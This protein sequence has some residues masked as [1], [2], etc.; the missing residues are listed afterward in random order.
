MRTAEQPG[1]GGVDAYDAC[2][3]RL[4]AAGEFS[5]FAN[6]KHVSW[7]QRVLRREHLGEVGTVW[8]K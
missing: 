5:V 8:M 1:L 4:R 2:L 7:F 3:I 6:D